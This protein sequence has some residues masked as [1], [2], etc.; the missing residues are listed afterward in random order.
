MATGLRQAATDHV[1]DAQQGHIQPRATGTEALAV[2]AVVR[3]SSGNQ[4]ANHAEDEDDEL[5]GLE[6]RLG[7]L[8]IGGATRGVRTRRVSGRVRGQ[9]GGSDDGSPIWYET[10]LAIERYREP[11]RSV[12]LTGRCA[13]C[14]QA[15]VRLCV[16]ARL[17]CKT[18]QSKNSRCRIA[19]HCEGQHRDFRG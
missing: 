9:I 19:G 8:G 3:D 4:H 12:R 1:A 2:I 10:R 16:Q 14:L 6:R 18:I 15:R 17:L 11:G 13:V 7:L 5:C